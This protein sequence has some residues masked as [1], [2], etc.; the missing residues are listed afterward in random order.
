MKKLYSLLLYIMLSVVLFAQ[1][2]PSIPIVHFDNTSKYAP[3]SG[4]SIVINPTGVFEIDNQFTLELLN[5]SGNV[6]STLSTVDEFYVPVLN[7]TLP[8]NLSPGKYKL[9]IKSSKPNNVEIT[10]EEFE[11]VSG[12]VV[13]PIVET[14]DGAVTKCI[15]G[16][17]PFKFIGILNAPD[18]YQSN[19]VKFD[20]KDG[21]GQNDYLITLFNINSVSKSNTFK[22]PSG[23]GLGTHIISVKRKN[24]NVI[25]EISYAFLIWGD[26]T[27][28]GN[29]TS[30]YIC[31]GE[32]VDIHI[33]IDKSGIGRNY[34]GS[35]Y[36]INFGDGSEEETFTH[37]NILSMGG[38]IPHKFIEPSCGSAAEKGFYKVDFKLF[39]K[40]VNALDSKL[41]DCSKYGQNGTTASYEV[42]VSTAPIADFTLNEKQCITE[43]IYATNRTTV[44]TY[45]TDNCLH[46][47][48]ATWS[49]KGP[50]KS[51]FED[52]DEA[53][54]SYEYSIDSYYNLRIYSSALKKG[55]WELRLTVNNSSPN[56]CPTYNVVTKKIMLEPTLTPNFTLDKSRVC[57]NEPVT[58]QNSTSYNSGCESPSWTW[59][60]SSDSY[61]KIEQVNG[62][63]T[64]I[65]FTQKETYTVTLSS[66]NTCGT[67]KITQNIE[68][69]EG[70]TA[71]LPKE[72]SVCQLPPATTTLDFSVGEIK[73][74]Y[75]TGATAPTSFNW[76]ISGGNYSFEGGTSALSKYPQIKFTEY[77]DYTIKLAV[78]GE[79]GNSSTQMTFSLRQMLHNQ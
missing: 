50:D 25:S 76:N 34:V 38:D 13:K 33:T 66:T 17:N 65:R 23:L 54:Y 61:S 40:G 72:Y 51:D 26:N 52:I 78:D 77:K 12:N 55:C 8:S 32:N 7:G 9:R 29:T 31:S 71:K 19:E 69:T 45:G 75:S 28:V 56:A 48:K 42:N 10:S 59:S 57:V 73:P 70:A 37:A 68:V 46:D 3:G 6:V 30:P 18:L 41:A 15:E 47:Y 44:G 39:D 79:C 64:L 43:D 36:T 27:N 1:D 16:S 20:L 4:V 67:K 21:G 11:V 74:E 60:T 49:V 14:Q 62:Y 2:G 24:G 58:T 53:F 22:T 5:A 35:L 63:N